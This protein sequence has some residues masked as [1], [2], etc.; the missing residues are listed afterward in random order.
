MTC[1]LL[2][3][4]AVTIPKVQ[5]SPHVVNELS[6]LSKAKCHPTLGDA[7]HQEHQ[8]LIYALVR[9]LFIPFMGRRTIISPVIE[10]GQGCTRQLPNRSLENTV[11]RTLH[12]LSGAP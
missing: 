4:L 2:C 8:N 6:W 3:I 11:L 12:P 7:V 9:D 1:L 10:S 5:P